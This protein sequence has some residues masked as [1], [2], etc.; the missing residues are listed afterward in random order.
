[1]V[2]G[3]KKLMATLKKIANISG[4]SLATVSRV[5]NFDNNL[6]VTDETRKRIFEVA[7]ELNYR[8]LKQ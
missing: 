8:T 5:L 3:R 7:E 4:F 6:S 2:F 1:M